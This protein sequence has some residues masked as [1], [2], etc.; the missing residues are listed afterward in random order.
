M[1]SR[2]EDS[3]GEYAGGGRCMLRRCFGLAILL[4]ARAYAADGDFRAGLWEGT[5]ERG[6]GIE[7]IV[8]SLTITVQSRDGAHPVTTA[9]ARVE[10]ASGNC[11]ANQAELSADRIAFDCQ[12]VD[13]TYGSTSSGGRFEGY[14]S[15][16]SNLVSG[17]W[18]GQPIQLTRPKQSDPRITD[19]EW[20]AENGGQTCVVRFFDG[21]IPNPTIIG[22]RAT[23][24]IYSKERAV[25]GRT[26]F[27]G[28]LRTSDRVSL[29]WTDTDKN[30]FEGRLDADAHQLIGK[31][32]GR[33]FLCGGPDHK[34]MFR[35]SPSS[36]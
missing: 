8:L 6:S 9:L 36:L 20:I 35:W 34:L 25:F 3:R 28:V 26:I 10:S 21:K 17:V 30:G 16:G 12:T 5:L 19:G 27:S 2:K 29:G 33:D 15:P 22:Q 14:F 23:I 24:D 11:A 31:W 1:N 7:K 4:A 13:V 18:R 32:N